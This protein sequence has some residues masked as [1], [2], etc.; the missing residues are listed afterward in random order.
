MRWG[1]VLYTTSSW[2]DVRIWFAAVLGAS[3]TD[4]CCVIAK[5]SWPATRLPNATA[6]PRIIWRRVDR[7]PNTREFGF[8]IILAPPLPGLFE[9][10]RHESTGTKYVQDHILLARARSFRTYC[11]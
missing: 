10:S 2:I 11:S 4:C 5:I 8:S 9:L 3:F 7:A 1:L 6:K